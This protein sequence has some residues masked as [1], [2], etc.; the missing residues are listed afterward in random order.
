MKV[1]WWYILA[2]LLPLYS[3][4]L[5]VGVELSFYKIL[6]FVAFIAAMIGKGQVF[7]SKFTIVFWLLSIYILL[8]TV[9]H[10]SFNIGSEFDYAIANGW[11]SLKIYMHMPTQLALLFFSLTQVFT[12][13]YLL[14]ERFRFSFFVNSYINGNLFSIAVGLII[15]LMVKINML[16]LDYYAGDM[17]RLSGLGGEPRHF[18]AFIV[19]ALLVLLIDDTNR[20]SLVKHRYIKIF[21]LAMGLLLSLSTSSIIAFALSLLIILMTRGFK[22]KTLLKFILLFTPFVII[23]S[24]ELLELFDRRVLDR[25]ANID[26][27]LYFAPKDALAIYFLKD[28]LDALFFGV[29]SGGITFHTMQTSFLDTVNNDL[30]L[31]TMIIKEVYNGNIGGSLSPSSFSIKFISEHGF[32]GFSLLILFFYQV[33]KKIKFIPYRRFSS[34]LSLVI[35]VSSFITSALIVYVYIIIISLLY[36]CSW[37]EINSK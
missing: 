19:V 32:F 28:N 10:Y 5:N 3:L 26:T 20:I 34:S 8:N 4:S 36:A 18:S 23:W 31:N 33:V 37:H 6:P 2:F 25:V 24:S 21:V 22:Y 17:L 14:K 1:S 13:A 27:F 16:S 35:L 11:N 12:F 30:V 9:L 29:G 15:W 7:S